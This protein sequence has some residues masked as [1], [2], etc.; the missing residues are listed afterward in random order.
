MRMRAKVSTRV[1]APNPVRLLITSEA[2]GD[3]WIWGRRTA[4]EGNI[5]RVTRE[6]PVGGRKSKGT[7]A[8]NDGNGELRASRSREKLQAA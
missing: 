2:T 3:Q 6:A 1:G 5:N 7:D 8:R 4:G